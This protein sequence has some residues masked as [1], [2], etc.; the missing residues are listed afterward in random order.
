MNNKNSQ[1]N[2]VNDCF[3]VSLIAATQCRIICWD[4]LPLEHY[5][6]KDKKIFKIFDLI[7][8]RDITNKLYTMNEKV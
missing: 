3:N 6:T 7:I 8:G 2:N 4:R 1:S 5:L